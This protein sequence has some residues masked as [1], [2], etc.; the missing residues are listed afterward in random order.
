VAGTVPG[1]RGDVVHSVSY[2]RLG[3]AV[4]L[5]AWLRVLVLSAAFPARPFEACTIGRGRTSSATISVARIGPL[6]PDAASRRAA[7]E[8]HLAVLADLFG[9][10]MCSPLPLYTKTSGAWAA[11]A[12]AGRDPHR[13]ASDEWSS[14]PGVDRE[15]K[16]PEHELVLGSVLPFDVMLERSGRPAGDEQA[17]A[18]GDASRFAAYARRL[19][20]GILSHEQVVDR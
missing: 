9:R 1:V 17:W 13:R 14:S 10:G 12:A 7:A 11:A 8:Q 5:I 6:G 2:S 20:D 15:D 4:R 18:P 19:W 16:D 3:P